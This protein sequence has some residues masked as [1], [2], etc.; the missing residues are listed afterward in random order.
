MKKA[1]LLLLC[2]FGIFTARSQDNNQVPDSL[3]VWTKG[4][5]VMFLFNQSTFTNWSAGGEN[6]ISGKTDINYSVNYIKDNWTWDNKLIVSYGLLK[7]KNS[8][9]VKKTDDRFEFTSLVGRKAT[10]QWIYSIILNLRTQMANGYIYGKDANGAET[11]TLTTSIMSP[12]YL[13][14]GPGMYWK[15]HNNLSVN[16]SPIASKFT[17]VDPNKTLPNEAYFG[18]KEGHTYRYE[19][20]FSAAGYY[21]AI[22]MANVSFENILSLYSNYLEDPQNVDINYQLNIVLRVNRYLTSNFSFQEIY[23]DNAFKGF[24]TRQVFGVG[25]NFGI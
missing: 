25:V 2:F 20:G 11:R 18:V 4:G 9:F 23:D 7:T 14:F 24:Q 17:F 15:K 13:T 8:A 5:N 21:K 19:L 3:K 16:L 22:I 12:G 6:T 1:A 10:G